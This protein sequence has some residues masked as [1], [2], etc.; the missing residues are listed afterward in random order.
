MSFARTVALLLFGLALA[1]ALASGKIYWI[2]NGSDT[3]GRSNLDGSGVEVLTGLTSNYAIGMA[4]DAVHRKVYWTRLHGVSRSNLDGSGVEEVYYLSNSFQWAIALDVAAGR[5]YWTQSPNRILRAKLDGTSVETVIDGLD[6]PRGIALDLS[7]GKV[8]WGETGTLKRIRRAN[9]NGSGVENLVASEAHVL[10]LDAGLGKMYWSNGANIFRANLNGSSVENLLSAPTFISALA[11]DALH[12]YVYWASTTDGGVYRAQ[13]DG[14]NVESVVLGLDSPDA[15][16]VTTASFCGDG[17]LDPGEA[18][19]DGNQTAGDGC[20][21]GCVVSICGDGIQDTGEECDDHNNVD[22]DG[23]S[24]DCTLP[25]GDNTLDPGEQC[26]D[27]NEVSGDGCQ[28]TCVLPVCGDAIVDAGEDCD[29]GNAIDFDGCQ[30]DCTTPP[31]VPKPDFAWVRTFS[32]NGHPVVAAD[33]AGNVYVAGTFSGTADFDP[34]P[35]VLELVSAGETDLFVLKLDP[36]GGLVWAERIGGPATETLNDVASDGSGVH[37]A[38]TFR[39]SVDFDPGPNAFSLTA[40]GSS[41][42]MFVVRLDAAGGLAW[43]TAVGGAGFEGPTAMALDP[44]ANAYVVGWVNN[45]STDF[46][47][48]PGVSAIHG[49]GVFVWSLDAGG[50]LR[51]VVGLGDRPTVEDVAFGGGAVHVVGEFT[52]TVDFNPG[53]GVFSQTGNCTFYALKLTALGGF[54]WVRTA[55]T[56][57][58]VVEGDIGLMQYVQSVAV[59]SAGEVCAVGIFEGWADFDPGPGSLVFSTGDWGERDGFVWKL[60]AGGNLATAA[61]LDHATRFSTAWPENVALDAD[62]NIYAAGFFYGSVDLD[63]GPQSFLVQATGAEDSFVVK[64]DAGGGFRWAGVA[65]GPGQTFTSGLAVAGPFV[66]VS[67]YFSEVTDFAP[68]PAIVNVASTGG[69]DSYVLKLSPEAPLAAPGEAS[70]PDVAA[71]QMR[72]KWIPADQEIELTY[73]PACDAADHTIYFGPLGAVASYGYAGAQCSAGVSGSVL[74]VAP[75]GDLFFLVV[76]TSGAR[77]GSYGRDSTGLERPESGRGGACDV[78]QDLASV[79]CR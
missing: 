35:G 16:A 69:E 8:Y 60:D 57:G 13:L 59:G 3:L 42:D 58:C 32:E 38:G 7:A 62:G 2:D 55:P 66:W 25:C 50:G 51:W 70:P 37:L 29:D 23:C 63:P 79:T 77:E 41:G 22:G 64:L 27:G 30:T 53:P 5:M 71:E 47:P 68:G 21:S 33:A 48:G 61:E 10:D 26:D 44:S 65:G 4:L 78:P 52:G 76:G 6:H 43:V 17:T 24:A 36:S 15:L 18:C 39:G 34:G 12:G 72:A 40:T 73:S 75:P 31:V 19:D 11:L 1:P 56:A 67:G 28:A 20:Q 46:D 45:T 9:L 49:P 54:V 74:F 14:S